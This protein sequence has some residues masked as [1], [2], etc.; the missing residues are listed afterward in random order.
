MCYVAVVSSPPASAGL[1]FIAAVARNGVM[2]RAGKLPWDLPEDRAHFRRTTWGH[3]VIMGR[4]TW[5]E[6]GRPLEGRRN[7]VV[8]RSG[9]VS[10][11][12][13][14]VVATL[15]EAIALA[16]TTDPDPFVIGGAEIFRQALPLANRMIL[17]EVDLD[18]EG[19]TYF[20]PFDRAEWVV[21]DRR[22]GDR[23]TY[24]T[25]ERA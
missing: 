2:G 12:G 10:G 17:T 16:R 13:R 15:E 1:T 11:A 19:D 6:T 3:A 7:I 14:E 9:Q 24:V 4:R 23:A 20:P 8:S 5:D 22:P 25:Y 18:V 21:A